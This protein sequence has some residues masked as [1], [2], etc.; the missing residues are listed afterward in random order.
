MKKVNNLE[1]INL[2]KLLPA[3]LLEDRDILELLRDTPKIAKALQPLYEVIPYN[4][5]SMLDKKYVQEM[6]GMEWMKEVEFHLIYAS[7]TNKR[8]TVEQEIVFLKT[9][10][11]KLERESTIIPEYVSECGLPIL[12]IDTETTSLITDFKIYGGTLHREFD[13]VG[14]PVATSGEC[15]YYLPVAHNE[16]D[17]VANFSLEAIKYFLQELSNRFF[18]VYFNFSYDSK[19]VQ[20][21]GVKLHIDRYADVFH[22][23]KAIG[24]DTL[25]DLGHSQGLKAQSEYF[26]DRKMLEI[27]EV[28]GSKQHIVFSRV[29]ATDAISYA[30][31]DGVN[32][33]KLFE[34]LVLEEE[35]EE[36]NPYLY[37]GHILTLDHRALWHSISMFKHN[38]PLNDLEGLKENTMTIINRLL[39]LED[40][41]KRIKGTDKFA[42]GSPDDVNFLL[43]SKVLNELL[44][45]SVGETLHIEMLRPQ[46]L[47]KF[48]K[49]QNFLDYISTDFGLIGKIENNKSRGEFM[50]FETRKTGWGRSAKGVPVLDYFKKNINSEY[51]SKMLKQ[52]FREEVYTLV[53][54]IDNYRGLVLE[55]QRLGK[56]YRYAVAD[57]RGYAVA[58]IE[59]QFNG[60]DTR[61][62]SNSSGTGDD[63][64]VLS[65]QKLDL[66]SYYGGQGL[67]GLNAQGLPSTSYSYI[68]KSENDVGEV[69]RI[70]KIRDKQFNNWLIRKKKI[71]KQLLDFNLKTKFS[72]KK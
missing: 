72:Q 23:S 65:G 7:K 46:V 10:L 33:F 19:V 9:F 27:G 56:M 70:I 41:Y 5:N 32:T 69:K 15:G 2:Y 37:N 44:M 38:L 34:T 68:K 13:L 40:K 30:V 42:I 22:I 4:P 25:P 11:E 35:S 50:K 71:L 55:L 48:P 62:F 61:R 47:K 67:A 54:T 39:V 21:I 64:L 3:D 36:F 66:I 1:D 24:I 58:S 6:E 28:V 29:C 16:T 59:L 18:L 45:D 20:H 63:R 17:G 31:S 49:V 26:L 57:D 51:W 53:D 52:R 60:T 14:V 12:A 43:G 8:K